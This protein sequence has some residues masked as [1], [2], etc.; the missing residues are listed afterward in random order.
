MRW[1]ALK[2][3]HAAEIVA[4]AAKLGRRGSGVW[5]RS[6]KTHLKSGIPGLL[7]DRCGL[8][9]PVWWSVSLGP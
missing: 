3:E 2:E 7:G 5:S 4:C 9:R 1:D 8:N 6:F